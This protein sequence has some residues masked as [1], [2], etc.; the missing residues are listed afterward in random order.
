[1]SKPKNAHRAD[2]V[3]PERRQRRRARRTARQAEGWNLRFE[4]A[5]TAVPAGL[6]KD[7]PM[8]LVAAVEEVCWQAA[9]EGWRARRP[10]RWRRHAYTAWRAQSAWLE[11]KRRRLSSMIDDALAAH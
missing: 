6:V 11:Q 8:L 2:G 9:A 3:H 1:M 5:G 10:H 4:S 7:S